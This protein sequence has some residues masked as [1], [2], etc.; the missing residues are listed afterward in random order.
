MVDFCLI[1]RPCFIYFPYIDNYRNKELGFYIPIESLPFSVA[2]TF[3]E[4]C[5]N[6]AVFEN[7]LYIS[8]V[9]KMIE[10]YD[11]VDDEYSSKRVVEYILNQCKE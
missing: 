6:I 4:L 9:K 11:C 8:K 3:K 5:D 1:Q 10:E 2:C 7:P